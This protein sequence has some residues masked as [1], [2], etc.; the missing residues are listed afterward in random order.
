M[1]FCLII[2]SSHILHELAELCNVVGIIEDAENFPLVANYEVAGVRDV[3]FQAKYRFFFNRIDNETNDGLAGVAHF[4]GGSFTNFG[5]ADGLGD[6]I[7]TGAN[8]VFRDDQGGI[9]VG[10]SRGVSHYDTRTLVTFGEAEGMDAGAVTDIE[11]TVDGNVWI[12]AGSKLSRFDGRDLIKMTHE[13]GVNGSRLNSGLMASRFC[14]AMGMAMV[15][16]INKPPRNQR[17]A[18]IQPDS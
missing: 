1:K 4:D 12:L 11:S 14:A 6:S 16:S 13:D 17:P 15:A 7:N 9:W 2:I 5:V 10:T 8:R 18:F 3:G